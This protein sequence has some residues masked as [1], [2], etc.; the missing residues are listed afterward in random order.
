MIKNNLLT[1]SEI[2]PVAQSRGFAVG[3]FSPRSTVMIQPVLHAAH[4]KRSPVIVQI[5]QKELLK[6][7][8]TPQSFIAA[9]LAELEK[10]S[11]EIPCVLHLDHT[12]DLAI[13]EA[14]IEAG[15]TSV[16]IDASE[17]NL[18]EN[19]R[20]SQKV[21]EYAHQFGVSVEAELGRIGATN[22]VETDS[23]EELFTRPDEAL[24]FV[25]E[26]NVDAL[27][28]SVGT[29]HG[30]YT[31][32]QPK[33]DLPRLEAIRSMISIPLVLHGGSGVPAAMMHTAIELN[34]GGVSKIN[35]AT[36]LELAALEAL[37]RQESI[38]DAQWKTLPSE[39]LRKAQAAVEAVTEDKIVHFVLSENRAADY[40]DLLNRR[41]GI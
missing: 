3:S 38:L 23:D 5:S 35:I 19:I 6:F 34:A 14:A 31:V 25:K 36:D 27:A 22:L 9:F 1:L 21:V 40:H 29:A 7:Q 20:I 4:N 28:V 41:K 39:D 30:V 13:I 2:L 12:K 33:I 26:T 10:I 17:M 15:F 11:T 8:V 16:M 37:Q 32:R 24:R 18:E